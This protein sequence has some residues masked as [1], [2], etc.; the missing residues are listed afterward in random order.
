MRRRPH[1]AVLKPAAEWAVARVPH[2][3]LKGLYE[4]QTCE[5]EFAPFHL[6]ARSGILGGG[7]S[8]SDLFSLSPRSKDRQR[9]FPR[10]VSWFK[11]DL[12]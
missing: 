11:V 9:A 10:E 4:M 2:S 7:D 12:D 8:R 5:T 3:V 1:Y 6:R